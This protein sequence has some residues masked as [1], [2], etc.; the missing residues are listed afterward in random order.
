MRSAKICTV[1][2]NV[3]CVQHFT[4]HKPR[5]EADSQARYG[6]ISGAETIR[7]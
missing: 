5:R 7:L 2:A 3:A 6:I 1:D 4:D